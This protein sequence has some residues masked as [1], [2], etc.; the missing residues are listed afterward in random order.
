MS[1]ATEQTVL[2]G[3]SSRA[4]NVSGPLPSSTIDLHRDTL[5]PNH[6]SGPLPSTTIDLH[7]DT[8][9]PNQTVWV[10]PQHVTTVV[11]KP[12]SNGVTSSKLLG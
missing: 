11:D 12:A 4:T 5:F 1:L 9:F 6:V 2:S 3:H 7:R 10:L 8:L